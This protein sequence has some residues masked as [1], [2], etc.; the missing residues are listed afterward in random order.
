M[1]D[2]TE[3]R[4][5]F[6]TSQPDETSALAS[7]LTDM[8]IPV[9]IRLVVS[10]SHEQ[11]AVSVIEAHM[12]SIGAAPHE[13]K[14]ETNEEADALLPCPNC[15]AVAIALRKPCAGCGYEI[16]AADAPPAFVK[17]HAAGALSFC[18]ECRDPLTFLSGKCGACGE[19]LEPLENDDRLCPSLKHVLYRDTA[20]GFVCKAC[21]RVWV[22]L[23]A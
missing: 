20:G 14:P 10:A 4:V 9:E 16:L 7:K 17:R 6:R 5:V 11:E 12:Q 18:P 2:E 22:D 8:G 1:S 19:E 13:D 15:E 3:L 21:E 23:A